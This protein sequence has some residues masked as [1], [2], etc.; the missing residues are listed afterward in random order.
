MLNWGASRRL[1]Y[2]GVLCLALC[3]APAAAENPPSQVELNGYLLGQYKKVLEPTFGAPYQET[4]SKDGW[5]YRV[6]V[7]SK[8]TQSYMAFKFTKD[9]PEHVFSIQIAG[10][11]GTNMLPFLGLRLG[12]DKSQVLQVLGKP[13]KVK[14]DAELKLELWSYKHRNYSVEVTDE[15]KMSSIQ[16]FGFEGFEEETPEAKT[17]PRFGELEQCVLGKDVDCLILVLAPDF[18][19]YKDRKTITFSTAARR[20]LSNPDS[21]LARLLLGDHDSLRAV[22]VDEK[23][24]G[25]PELRLTMGGPMR[26]V[27]KFYNSKIISE[28]VYNWQAGE[29]RVWEVRFH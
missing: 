11:A 20:E 14:R 4:K 17:F 2:A 3:V 16:I 13:S 25:E 24:K 19:V 28:V 15:G 12:D 26:H 29:W 22:F 5:V 9:D 6:Y 8:E 10:E 23:L 1:F 7:L 27:L 21:P 18:E